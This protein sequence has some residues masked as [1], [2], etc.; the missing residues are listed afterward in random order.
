MQQHSRASD[1]F[2]STECVYGSVLC[3]D[4]D[5][6]CTSGWLGVVDEAVPA[7]A[8]LSPPRSGSRHGPMSPEISRMAELCDLNVG[9][10]Q[11]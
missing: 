1:V 10:P 8:S 6:G 3:C 5:V 4:G 11:R 2:H 7:T 9:I